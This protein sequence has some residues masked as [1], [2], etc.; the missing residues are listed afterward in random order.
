[1]ASSAGWAFEPDGTECKEQL[2]YEK[3]R[4][5]RLGSLRELTLGLGPNLGGDPQSVYHRS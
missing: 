2:M 1:M 4:V 3:P 5:E